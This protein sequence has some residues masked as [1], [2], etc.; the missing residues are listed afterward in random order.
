MGDTM[1]GTTIQ[2]DLEELWGTKEF[3]AETTHM[4]GKGTLPRNSKQFRSQKPFQ[5]LYWNEK[6]VLSQQIEGLEFEAQEVKIM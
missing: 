5:I 2:P 1:E 3:K 6:A 4:K